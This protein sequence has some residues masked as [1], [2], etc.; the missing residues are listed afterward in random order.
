M[1]IFV[2][3]IMTLV[4]KELI[5]TLYISVSFLF[6]WNIT[7]HNNTSFFVYLLKFPYILA[8]TNFK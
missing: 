6:L 8:Q 2:K 7:K 1:Q 3:N 4:L 5:L